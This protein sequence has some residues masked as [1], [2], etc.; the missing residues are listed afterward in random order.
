MKKVLMIISSILFYIM[1]LLIF[2]YYLY[3]EL[4]PKVSMDELDRIILLFLIA[5]IFYL[6][7]FFLSKYLKNTK[8]MKIYLY[9]IF[10]FYFINLIKLTLFDPNYGRVGLNFEGWS[11]ENFQIYLRNNNIIPLKTIIE[12]MMRGD[13][14][15][16][17]NLLGNIV[18]FAPMGIF[19]PILF[20]R[21]K[22][23]KNFIL[24]N[25]AIILGI[26]I[27]QFLTLSGSFDIDD[28]ILNLLGALIVYSL[29]KIRKINKLINKIFLK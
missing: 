27:L 2:S 20:D 4:A 17:I 13:R 22:K 3:L 16:M 9:C 15:A 6:G 7:S 25:I 28:F 24:T 11:K 1:G 26:E 8:P 18:A 5:L 23:L 12:Y 19:L 21:E 14:V 29:Y 10:I